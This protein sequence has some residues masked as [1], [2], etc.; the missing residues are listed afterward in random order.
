MSS[1]SK[2][3]EF[4]PDSRMK[5]LYR[6]YVLLF[7]ITFVLPWDIPL[8]IV[9]LADIG[10]FIAM[11]I[12]NAV[13]VAAVGYSLWWI[14]K[15]YESVRFAIDEEGV[16]AEYGVFWRKI[17]KVSFAKIHLVQI[18][19]GP[20]QRR[21]GLYNVCVHTAAMGVPKAEVTLFQ[22]CNAD[23]IRDM[24]LERIGVLTKERRK[25]VEERILDTLVA[26][27]QFLEEKLK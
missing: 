14:P 13:I 4:K 15:F 16:V 10:A 1:G 3:I 6:T 27:K 11:M 8:I 18:T 24:I 19:Q 9:S 20:L 2:V 17:S 21:F 26:I 23:Q 7:M 22:V 5:S 25:S 12:I